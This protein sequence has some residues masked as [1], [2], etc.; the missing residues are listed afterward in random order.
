MFFGMKEDRSMKRVT[1]R[2]VQDSK[3][4]ANEEWCAKR[5]TII[6]AIKTDC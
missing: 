4:K 5:A 2:T 3:K 1:K 6:N